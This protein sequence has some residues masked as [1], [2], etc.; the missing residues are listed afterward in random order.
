M[1]ERIVDLGKQRGRWFRG[2]MEILV[3][4]RHMLFNKRYGAAG[5]IGWP[6]LLL[7][8]FLGLFIEAF[9]Y[10]SLPIFALTK[11]L[12]YEYLLLFI[13]VS[14]GY[15]VL[16]SVLSVLVAYW[17]EPT[18]ASEIHGKPLLATL[19]TRDI[20]KLLVYCVIENIGYRQLT[21]QWRLKGLWDYLRGNKSWDK[22]ERI[23]FG[24]EEPET[25]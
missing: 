7:F 2:F 6:S 13:T 8:D 21:I 18:G 16:V 22:F 11:I 3:Y 24:G 14:F 9:G 10:I 5:M 25:S 1:P 4:H 19:P 17:T 12:S 23:G 15:G 20:A